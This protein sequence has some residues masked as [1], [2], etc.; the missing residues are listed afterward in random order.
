MENQSFSTVIWVDQTPEEV[1]NVILDVR[2]WWSGLFDESFEGSSEKVGD[3]FS[4]RAGNGAHYTR[5]KLIELV[6]GKKVVWL[7]TDSNL[8]FVNTVDEWTGT[9]IVFEILEEEGKTKIV[10][11]HLGLVPDF[12][13]YDACSSAWTQY[14]RER[15]TNAV[16][17]LDTF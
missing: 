14:M 12:E 16:V 15:L 10:F 13:C 11:S 17:Q 6:P 1:F 2:K 4:F 9:K 8:S 3:E 7:V 5:Q